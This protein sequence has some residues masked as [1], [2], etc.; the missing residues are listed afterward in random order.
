MKRSVLL[1]V[2]A[3][4][5]AS[6]VLAAPQCMEMRFLDARG[7]VLPVNP[8]LIGIMVGDAPLFEGSPPQYSKLEAGRL[9]PCP[10]QLVASV[11][12]TFEDSCTSDEKRKATAITNKA[13]ISLVNKRCAD[14]S[15]TLL[16]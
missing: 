15:N 12:K 9:L 8:P 11:R 1:A 16:K 14:L 3:L 2:A 13:D 5:Y 10:E 6:P 4:F 7:V